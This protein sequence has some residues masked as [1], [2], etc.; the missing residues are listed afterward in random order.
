MKKYFIPLSHSTAGLLGIA[1]FML[2]AVL[3]LSWIRPWRIDLTE[4]NLYTLS[5]GTLNLLR[6]IEGDPIRFDFY[7]SDKVTQ[8]IPTLRHYSKRVREILEEYE[9]QSNGKIILNVIDPEPFS[10]AEDEAAALGLQGIPAGNNDTIYFGLVAVK[11]A[12]DT[13]TQQ[14]MIPFFNPEKENSLEYE[15]SQLIYR[16]QRNKP[17]VVGIISDI[18]VFQH[19]D[20]RSGQV[21]EPKIILEQLRQMFD[22]RRVYDTEIHHIDDEIDL[23]MVIHPHLWS[24]N[25]LYAIDQFVL[26]GGRLV[27]FMD[28]KAEMDNSEKMM[29]GN[30]GM[31]DQSSSLEQLLTSWGVQYD[32]KQ[33]LLDYGFAHTIPVTQYGQSLPHVGV[34]GIRD[35]GFN[36]EEAMSANADQVNLAT[37]GAL[38][39]LPGAATTFT[40]LMQSSSQAQLVSTE[41]YD[42]A[43]NHEALLRGFASDGKGPYSIAAFI[44]GPVAS[45]F[46]EGMPKVGDKKQ[47][48]EKAATDQADNKKPEHLKSSTAPAAIVL[49]ADTDIL[50]DR[51]WVQVQDF[52]GQ[53]VAQPWASNSDLILNVLEKLGGSVDL[54]NVRGRGSYNRPF[55]RVMELERAASDVLRQEE[56]SLRQKLSETEDRLMALS[57]DDQLAMGGEAPELTAEQ[58]LELE[59]FQH[60]RLE[61]RKRLREVQHQ[62]SSDIEKLGAVLKAINM[63]AVPILLLLVWAIMAGLKR[64]SSNA[65]SGN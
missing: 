62:L 26:R 28:P 59:K 30:S 52:Y 3:F 51:M 53:K 2:A 65:S 37:T 19:R 18:P 55:D 43:G 47:G 41:T 14:D 35:N 57:G 8:D 50:D 34:L 60:E 10:E 20:M 12:K 29:F 39:P 5:P 21:N 11:S 48:D 23:L 40:P 13:H 6:G 31:E 16:L 61:I 25:T 56:E 49:F 1:A 54:I 24:E 33:V 38:F 63:L 44:T 32:P 64:R 7:Y 42:R 15:I 9:L 36:R 27:A 22:V 46:P 45:A 4:N 17:L 58:K